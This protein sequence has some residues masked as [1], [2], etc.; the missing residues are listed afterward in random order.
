MKLEKMVIAN[1]SALSTAILWTICSIGVALMPDFVE[2]V[3]GWMMHGAIM[4]GS[5]EI[6][7]GSYLMGGISLVIMAWLWGWLFGWAWEYVSKK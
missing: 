4:S 6:N 1:A 5:L 7:F 3:R 2:T